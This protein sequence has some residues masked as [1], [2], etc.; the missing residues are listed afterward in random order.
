M[1]LLTPR[2]RIEAIRYSCTCC[3]GDQRGLMALH[4]PLPDSIFE[5][6]EDQRDSRT[7]ISSDLCVL[8][9]EHFF[10]RAV[11]ALPILDTDETFDFGVWGSLKRENFEQ[12]RNEFKNP[13]PEFGPFFSWLNST[14]WPYPDTL[15]MPSDLYFRGDNLRPLMQLH[16]GDHPLAIDQRA[17]ITIDKVAEIYAAWGHTALL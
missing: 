12:Y 16:A 10:V 13:A 8:D 7:T 5:V 15:N 3:G 17:G 14:L 6:P 11:L 9:D 4:K 1:T 2:Q